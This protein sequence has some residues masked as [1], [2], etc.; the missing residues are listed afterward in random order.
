M[1]KYISTKLVSAKEMNEKEW[2][3][4]NKEEFGGRYPLDGFLIEYADGYTS[5]CPK[6]AFEKS[7]LAVDDNPKLPSGVS[8]GP[9]M[10]EDFIKEVHVSKVGDK[11]TLVRVVL[12]NGFEIIETSACVDPSNYNQDIG[13]DVC[14]KKVKDK[15]W[16][17]LGFLL[18][19]AYSGIN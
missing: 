3:E 5:W 18:Q 7:Y 13:T 15:I 1:K 6:Y 10:V 14:M 12:L 19:T 17:H 11:S 4:L 16:Q 8:V 2:K 9:R